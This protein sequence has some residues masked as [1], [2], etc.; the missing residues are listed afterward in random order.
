MIN[1]TTSNNI[2]FKGATRWFKKELFINNPSLNNIIRTTNSEFVGTLP[3]DILQDIIK[4]S[5]NKEDKTKRIKGIMDG[6][7][8]V[9]QK[10]E[11]LRRKLEQYDCYWECNSSFKNE[12]F[13]KIVEKILNKTF[14]KGK[15]IKIGEKIKVESL[16][17]GGFGDVFLI[18][19]PQST[20]Y[21][22]LVLKLFKYKQLS[23]FCE[24]FNHGGFAENN[25]MIYV[26]NLFKKAKEE[27]VFAEGHF[28]SLKNIFLVS[29]YIHDAFKGTDKGTWWLYTDEGHKI[30][31]KI[32]ETLQKHGLE[33]KDYRSE[34]II[35]GKIVDYGGVRDINKKYEKILYDYYNIL[36]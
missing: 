26:N 29:E 28:G 10:I 14:R 22:S 35:N 32:R 30:C 8:L 21:K 5:K 17:E 16:G 23:E 36:F 34:N 13:I 20:Q 27:S 31:H 1:N 9:V 6:F 12:K 18:K 11:V 7:S 19:F 3:K 2:S 24:T 33:Y 4:I 15:L 25:I